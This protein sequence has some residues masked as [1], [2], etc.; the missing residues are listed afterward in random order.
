M[1]AMKEIE[2]V[3]CEDNEADDMNEEAEK[4][5]ATSRRELIHF[6]HNMFS[7]IYFPSYL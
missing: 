2:D 7:D 4:R 5:P 3:N 1:S 6:M